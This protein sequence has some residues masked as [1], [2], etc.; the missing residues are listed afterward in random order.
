MLA[1]EHPLRVQAALAEDYRTDFPGKREQPAMHDPLYPGMRRD[2]ER[3][4]RGATMSLLGIATGKS[5]RG[6]AR[7]LD[8]EGWQGHFVTIQTADDNP[9]KPR[10]GH[11]PEG[12][13]AKRASSRHR[14]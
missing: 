10:P 11:D 5:Q 12:H 14:P 9:S 13:G 4:W 7:L 8:R 3:R 6:V 1:A 2:G